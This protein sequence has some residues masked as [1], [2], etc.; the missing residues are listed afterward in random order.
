MNLEDTS[1][2]FSPKKYINQLNQKFNSDELLIDTFLKI[3]GKWPVKTEIINNIE[4]KYWIDDEAFNWH[5]LA[6]RIIFS[7]NEETNKKP[8]NAFLHSTYLL[9]GSDQRKIINLFPPDK[10]RAHLNFIY[11][12]VLEE[13]IICFNEMEKNKDIIN[14]FHAS[15]AINAVYLD[16][17]GYNFSEFKRI[18]E[19]EKKIKLDKFDSLYS[20]YDFLYWSWKYRIKKSTPEKIAYDSQSGI[21]FLIN[22]SKK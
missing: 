20:Y 2:N 14:Q 22:M 8:L 15:D 18:Y 9:P 13:V 21:N 12:V 3:I 10:Y 7:L 11:G 1:V 19:F 17:Y 5:L 6:T 4:Y 16:L